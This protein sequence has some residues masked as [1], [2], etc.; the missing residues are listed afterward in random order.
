MEEK[1]NWEITPARM[2]CLMDVAGKVAKQMTTSSWRM[3]FE[4]MEAVLDMIQ[5]EIN[6]SRRKNEQYREGLAERGQGECF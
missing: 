6:E 2:A 1:R 5:R 3:T 4:E